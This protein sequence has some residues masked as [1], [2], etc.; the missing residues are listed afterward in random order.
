MMADNNMSP[1]KLNFVCSF[2]TDEKECMV[3]V[4]KAMI[5]LV[6]LSIIAE[7]SKMSL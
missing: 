7:K 4:A 2:G 6:P 3:A 5:K 1:T